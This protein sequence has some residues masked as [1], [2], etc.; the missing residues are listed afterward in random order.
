MR[1]GKTVESISK[2]DISKMRNESSYQ[3][4]SDTS[5]VSSRAHKKRIGSFYTPAPLANLIAHDTI[6]AWLSKKAKRPLQNLEEIEDL[7]P[8]K[9]KQLLNAT[10][11]ISI[12]D[13]AVGDGVFLLA[14]G[15]WLERIQVA[16]DDDATPKELRDHI[17]RHCLFGVDLSNHAVKLCNRK[18]KQWGNCQSSSILSNLKVGNSLV[19]FIGLN[20]QIES[21]QARLNNKLFG[22]L[23]TG[24]SN[25]ILD[26]LISAKPLHWPLAFPEIFSSSTPGFDVIL[27]NPPYGS[28]LGPIERKHISTVFDFSVGGSRD[29]TW[30]S[31]AHFLVR[32]VSLMK[33]GAELGFLVP[34]SFLRV[35]Q[36][37]KIRNYLLNYT[38]LWKI[39]DEGSPFADVTLEMVSIFSERMTAPRDHEVVIESRRPG[40]EQSNVVSSSVFRKSQVFSIYHDHIMDKIIQRGK[41]RLLVARRGRDIP[42][43]HVRKAKSEEFVIP[44]ITSGRSVRRYAFNDMHIFYTDDWYKQDTSLRESFEHEFLVATKNYRYPRCVLKPKGVIHGGG[45]VNI[46]PLYEG[47]DLHVL[48]LILNSKLV[49]QISIRY[50]TNYSQLTCCLNTGMMENL[51]LV[52]PKRKQVYRDVFDTL[53][54]LYS[55]KIELAKMGNIPILERLADALVY[56]LYFGDATL[57]EKISEEK[58][59]VVTIA[60]EPD[61]ADMIDEILN[62][63]TVLEL[64]QL[65]SFPPSRKTR[66]Y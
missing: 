56:S 21:T 15:E 17:V 11:N 29:G 50:L 19:G 8:V 53:S 63:N 32:A 43:K 30:N 58:Q 3:I 5:L 9:K 65:G 4:S 59:D 35:K 42:K 6:F 45:I 41:K 55:H 7:K 14:A 22:L 33:E 34:N 49:R 36:F 44:Y 12:L 64:E 10:R 54:H 38:N 20:N 47:A 57:E 66:R 52:L 39:V 31:A 23:S 37:S 2:Q 40:L 1:I 18:L 24:K 48:G 61:V 13:P 26:D 60:Q 28:I 16:L 62:E 51:P 27:A 25:E 46:T